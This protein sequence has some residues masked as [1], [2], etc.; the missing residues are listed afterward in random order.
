MLDTPTREAV[1][2]KQQQEVIPVADGAAE[3]QLAE[4]TE[5]EVP[6]ATL[7][8]ESVCDQHADASVAATETHEE[9]L[10][11]TES[12]DEPLAATETQE[13]PLADGDTAT[14]D[15]DSD[16]APDQAAAEQEHV[17]ETEPITAAAE[18]SEDQPEAVEEPATEPVTMRE[19]SVEDPAE[20]QP[21]D[22]EYGTMV[23][24]VS[25][26]DDAEKTP[27]IPLDPVSDTAAGAS[28]AEEA[29]DG[30][31][32]SEMQVVTEELPGE[33]ATDKTGIDDEAN[34]VS[35]A[36]DLEPGGGDQLQ[37]ASEETKSDEDL[38]ATS[39]GAAAVSGIALAS[40][41]AE[42]HG[43]ISEVP[44]LL[45]SDEAVDDSK[46]VEARKPEVSQPKEAAKVEAVSTRELQEG[47]D[48]PTPAPGLA[49][50]AALDSAPAAR[51][52]DG[53]STTSPE[54]AAPTNSRAQTFCEP[55]I[56]Q[57][58]LLPHRSFAEYD[59]GAATLGIEFPDMEMVNLHQARTLR[60]KQKQALRNA[61]DTVAAAVI[62]YAAADALN[63]SD[64][65][66]RVITWRRPGSIR[67]GASDGTRVGGDTSRRLFHLKRQI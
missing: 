24:Q 50:S 38:V 5:A 63:P 34:T 25:E 41:S 3:G 16:P 29:K 14:L 31:I 23:P 35:S 53:A 21:D 61:E 62:I 2:D 52:L 9:P 37:N 28:A 32:S 49:D 48:R 7:M 67:P 6:D 51:D 46:A 30:V 45:E 26:A 58:S 36:A 11:S 64:A 4:P 55:G 66:S 43:E 59:G 18:T 19:L 33:P 10:V 13:E 17:H 39:I 27:V 60:R 65:E 8:E 20:S 57:T 12:Q 44:G 40:L 1:E 54:K 56:S 47:E 22:P 42:Q 15:Y